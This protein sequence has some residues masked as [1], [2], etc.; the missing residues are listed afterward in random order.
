MNNVSEEIQGQGEKK[1]EKN[2]PGKIRAQTGK[3][4]RKG[5]KK[6]NGTE[7]GS[8]EVLVYKCWLLLTFAQYFHILLGTYNIT[9]NFKAGLGGRDE[10]KSP[11][12]QTAFQ[13]LNSYNCQVQFFSNSHSFAKSKPS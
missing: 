8:P 7:M 11:T 5:M 12:R 13:C 6:R 10:G 9:L 2:I 4:H 1:K 3:A